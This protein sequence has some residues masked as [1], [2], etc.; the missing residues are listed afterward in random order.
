MPLD[1]DM[2]NSGIDQHHNTFDND[3]A[4]NGYK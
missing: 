1:Q 3:E 4:T 2:S